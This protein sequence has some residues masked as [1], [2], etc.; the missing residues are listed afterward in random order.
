[1]ADDTAGFYES[2]PILTDF[3]EAVQAENYRPL[4]DEWILGFAD[5]AGSTRAIDEG[6]YKAVN[7]VAAGVVAAVSPFPPSFG[8][9]QF[10][11]NITV[12]TRHRTEVDGADTFR[13]GDV[14]RARLFQAFGAEGRN[15][16]RHVLQLF[17]AA[18]APD[19]VIIELGI[20][21]INSSVGSSTY[22]TN[23]ASLV[24][25]AQA[26]GADVLMIAPISSGGTIASQ[27]PYMAAALDVANAAGV[28]YFDVNA[29]WG[30]FS[31]ANA[32]GFM[33]SDQIHPTAAGY[34]NEAVTIKQIITYVSP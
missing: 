8:A 14:D 18:V 21:D 26:T 10:D 5:I 33:N 17:V 11:Q 2:L 9:L 22:Q 29:K 1:M 24:S 12:L 23:L 13:G 7:F 16:D 34:S 25:Q 27:P 6:R 32:S 31:G 15:G 3:A 20:N 28:P 4:P 30:G 19:L